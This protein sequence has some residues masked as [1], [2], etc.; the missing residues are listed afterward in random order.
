V[1]TDKEIY[2]GT[3][4]MSKDEVVS[5]LI[6]LNSSFCI[7]SQDEAELKAKMMMTYS[8]PAQRLIVKLLIVALLRG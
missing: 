3:A 2:E 4:Q 7:N 8:I 6:G 1:L 5:I